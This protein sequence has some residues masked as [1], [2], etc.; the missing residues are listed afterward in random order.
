MG[1]ASGRV[2][3]RQFAVIGGNSPKG[4]GQELLDGLADKKFATT[5]SIAEEVE[6]GW[7]GGA[8]VYDG[9]FTFD[10]NV[11]GDALFFALRIDTNKVPGSVKQAYTQMEEVAVAKDNPSGFISKAQRKQVRDTVRQ[12]VEEEQKSG[13]YRKSKIVP[14]LWDL[15]TRRVYASASG[16]T[17]EKLMEIFERTFGLQLAPVTAGEIAQ[18]FLNGRIGNL[19]DNLKPTRFV[20]G[21]DGDTAYPDYPWSG[22]SHDPKAFLG[23]E[24]ATWLLYFEK[25]EGGV[26]PSYLPDGPY[27]NVTI[28]FDRVLELHC[29]YGQTGKDAIRGDGPHRSPE[30]REA[31]RTGKVP[32][33]AGMVI[34]VADEPYSLTFDPETFS[35]GGVK[36]PEIQEADTPRVI[37]EER[38][39]LMAN[40]VKG[41][42]TLF[43]T[44]MLLRA[45]DKA[46][47]E[48]TKEI[49]EWI[50]PVKKEEP[51]A[52][53]A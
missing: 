6:Y 40:M 25:T 29:A 53:E 52:V 19:F 16:T 30:V 39:K 51:E 13:K 27:R 32:R 24:F 43:Q 2:S 8:H 5:S 33:K 31:L 22:K 9:E 38:I 36:L 42:E 44:F 49:A 37:F 10:K 3:F 11:F 47:Q 18:E 15:E 23:N 7:S 4:V 35:Y 14:I 28:F 45:D 48:V 26:I 17:I 21:V 12:K 1:F 41:F 46:W 20:I 34:D 50:Q